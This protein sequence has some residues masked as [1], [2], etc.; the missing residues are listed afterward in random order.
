MQVSIKLLK[1]VFRRN[2]ID[3]EFL[4]ELQRLLVQY[5]DLFKIDTKKRLARFLSMSYHE[6]YIKKNGKIRIRENL[7][8]KSKKQL[9]KM[10]YYFR[11]HPKALDKAMSLKGEE[12][13]K[14][15]AINWYGRG[16]KAKDLG[17]IKP[18][19]GWNYRGVGI[20]QVTGRS[21]YMSVFKIIEQKLGIVCFNEQ[22]EV[23][24]SLLN[25]YFGAIISA[26]GYWYM[27]KMYK[28]QNSKCV[29]DKIN[30]GLPESMKKERVNTTIRILNILIKEQSYT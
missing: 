17:N 12:K 8:Y 22:G 20:F 4:E 18:I 13:Q 15:I 25:S 16:S 19:D 9:I 11:T 27:R 2:N 5:G 24:Q 10:S 28:C 23:Y 14:F 1:K 7:N 26:F 21:N 29:I 30:S 6:I 3:I